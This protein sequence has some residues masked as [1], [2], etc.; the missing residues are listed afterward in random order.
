MGAVDEANAAIGI[1][2]IHTGGDMDAILA[3]IQNDLFD[4]GVGVAV[5]M[6]VRGDPIMIMIE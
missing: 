6:E 5:P 1:A 3:R 2:R 4:L